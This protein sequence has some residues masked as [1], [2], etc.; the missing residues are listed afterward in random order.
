MTSPPTLR[1]ELRAREVVIPYRTKSSQPW[2]SDVLRFAGET[3]QPRKSWRYTTLKKRY[4]F[5]CIEDRKCQVFAKSVSMGLVNI[6]CFLGKSTFLVGQT[7]GFGILVKGAVRSY[8]A[9]EVQPMSTTYNA[10]FFKK[11]YPQ[12]PWVPWPSCSFIFPL[13]SLQSIGRFV[14]VI[15]HVQPPT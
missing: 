9:V 10:L 12:I 7:S 15:P 2:N 5:Q 13:Q 1:L 11:A 6:Q 14:R 4:W 8:A 3:I